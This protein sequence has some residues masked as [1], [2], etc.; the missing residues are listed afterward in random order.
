M[1]LTSKPNRILISQLPSP[2]SLN[3]ECLSRRQLLRFRRMIA[4]RFW[5]G[6][7]HA[8]T[9]AINCKS[10][11]RRPVSP[12]FSVEDSKQTI[13]IALHQSGLVSMLPLRVRRLIASYPRATGSH[14]SLSRPFDPVLSL[15]AV[16]A[17]LRL[18]KGLAGTLGQ[19]LVPPLIAALSTDH[20]WL[21]LLSTRSRCALDA[22]SSPPLLCSN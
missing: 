4:G 3:A 22:L 9:A 7:A 5:A 14:S 2:Q 17:C 11:T 19:Y 20:Y 18:N 10:R 6:C 13:A 8:L 16:S 12:C 1:S 21:P 15:L